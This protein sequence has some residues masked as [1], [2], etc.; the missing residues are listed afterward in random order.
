MKYLTT[1][2]EIRIKSN[3]LQYASFISIFL[4]FEGFNA[5]CLNEWHN[6]G[7]VVKFMNVAMFNQFLDNFI[8]QFED[9]F[10]NEKNILAKIQNILTYTIALL[11][12]NELHNSIVT[13]LQH[14][15]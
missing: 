2:M 5:E 15:N 13:I 3:Q 8:S 6:D 14:L 10:L 7:K 9:R 12:E 4:W 1:Q 11:E